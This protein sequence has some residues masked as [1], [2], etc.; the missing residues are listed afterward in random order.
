MAEQAEAAAELLKALAHPGRLRILCLLVEGERSVGA[1]NAEVALSQSALSQHLALLR[2]Q[3]LVETRREAQTI[4]YSLPEGPA[5]TL[6]GSLHAL[7]CPAPTPT[8]ARR[9]R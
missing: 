9:K 2:E 5:R 4:F 1:I 6:L 8:A 3:G 7:Y